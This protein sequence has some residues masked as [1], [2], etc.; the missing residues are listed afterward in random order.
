M[1][2][3]RVGGIKRLM[4][5]PRSMA[6]GMS[7]WPPYLASGVRVEE[8]AEDFSVARVR[9]ARRPWNTN[10]VGTAF[11]GSLFSMSDP[12][13]MFLVMNQ[14]GD[15]YTVWD[16][17]GEI[18]FVRPGTGTVHG[19]FR[20]SPEDIAEIREQAADGS[21]VLRWFETDLVDDAGETIAR[22]RKQVYVRRKRNR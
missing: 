9:L 14:L 12:F 22:V 15:A 3:Q 4:S 16:T 10:Y 2:E 5:S 21:K 1:S 6:I 8:I 7:L 20:V 18:T 17:A 11:G 19:E 13:W